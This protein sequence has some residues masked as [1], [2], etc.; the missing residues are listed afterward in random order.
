MTIIASEPRP[1]RDGPVAVVRG[2]VTSGVCGAALAAFAVGCVLE[3]VPLIVGSLVLPVAYGLLNLLVGLPKRARQAAVVPVQA[4]AMIESLQAT[5]SELTANVPIDFDLTVVPDDA[6][7][8]RVVMS[9]H[10]NLVDVPKYQPRGILVVEYPPDR[11][12]KIRLVKEP[13]PEWR[14]RAADAQLDSAPGATV[15]KEPPQG[16]VYGMALLVGFLVGVALVPWAFCAD[17]ADSF[18]GSESD[19]ATP[20]VTSSTSTSTSSSSSSSTNTTVVSSASGTVV[21]GVGKSFLDEGELREA[22]ESLTKGTH[23]APDAHKGRALTV[24]VNDKTLAM[25]FPPTGTQIPLFDPDSLPYE[26]VPALVRE[27]TTTLG[28][29]SPQ[30]WQLTA[31]RLTG[32]LRLTVT[33]SGLDGDKAS[34]VADGKGRAILRTKV[35]S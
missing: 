27:A 19:G 24:T 29:S 11:P 35:A 8:F 13:T 32:S 7:A 20:S 15:V 14:R 28:V 3:N 5:G 9:D 26:R 6:P 1:T 33:V 31:E 18:G 10:I 4:L 2:F 23:N 21:L 34:L 30:S 22:V 16:T 17:L 25:V 12:W